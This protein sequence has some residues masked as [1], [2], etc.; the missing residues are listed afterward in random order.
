MID[1]SSRK[2]FNSF[3]ESLSNLQE[4]EANVRD[5]YRS[6][7][8]EEFWSSLI[9]V[10]ELCNISDLD[11]IINEDFND[12]LTLE[13]LL[14]DFEET[15]KSRRANMSREHKERL[16]KHTIKKNCDEIITF[17]STRNEKRNEYINHVSL[18]RRLIIY[19]WVDDVEW[20]SF[21][22]RRCRIRWARDSRR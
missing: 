15:R 8:D 6:F 9:F 21:E 18:K 14:V 17:D 19:K 3:R 11:H 20:R 1:S 13:E 7:F 12:F 22:R 5:I 16:S 2:H 10:N 4:I